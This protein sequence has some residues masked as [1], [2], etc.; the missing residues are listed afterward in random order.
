M[1]RLFRWALYLFIVVVV[2][3]VAGLLLLDTIAKEVLQSRLRAATGMDVKIGKVDIGLLTPTI[4]IEGCKLYSTAEFGGSPCL[5][6]NE[7]Y[8]EYDKEALRA[9]KLHFRLVRL[10]IA[11]MDIIKDKQGRLNLQ[12]IGEKGKAAGAVIQSQAS[13]FSFAGIDMLNLSFQKLR[14]S[15]LDPPVRAQEF[16]FDLTNQVFPNLKSREDW[17]GVA[18]VL[19]GRSGAASAAGSPPLDLQGLF[20][21]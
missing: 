17:T 9:R 11:E 8:L 5:D 2:L 20:L 13:A 10:S 14:L 12:G 16:N 19:A 3:L 21:Q 4:A 6:L 1:K 15:N 7:L 18:V